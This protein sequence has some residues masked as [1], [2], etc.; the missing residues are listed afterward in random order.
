[1]NSKQQIKFCKCKGSTPGIL[2]FHENTYCINFAYRRKRKN[3]IYK[4]KVQSYTLQWILYLPN[5]YYPVS[6]KRRSLHDSS[7][8]IA[9]QVSLL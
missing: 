9:V 4:I 1:M 8:T 7:I 5:F 6:C 3:Q 2:W